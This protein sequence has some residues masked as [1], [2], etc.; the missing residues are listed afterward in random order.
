M[1]T[2]TRCDTDGCR[3]LTVA[4]CIHCNNHLCLKCL[5][6]HQQPI[7]LQISQLT[8]DMNRL[9]A[10]SCATDEHHRDDDLSMH[11]PQIN[12]NKQYKSLIEQ[13]DRWEM[14][15][16]KRLN[17]LVTQ[18]RNAARTSFEQISFEIEEWSTER[19]IEIQQL[20]DEI[21]NDKKKK[22]F[23]LEF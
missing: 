23:S 21:G 8:N 7:D 17:G 22:N 15:M 19:Q 3:Q 14:I 18:A 16:T 1:S 12:A 9:L 13:I 10:I 2:N 6:R 11:H 5:T 4:K 20:T